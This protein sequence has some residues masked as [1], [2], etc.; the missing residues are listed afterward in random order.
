MERDQR[1]M[2]ERDLDLTK[3]FQIT[4]PG[5]QYLDLMK[6]FRMNENIE[7]HNEEI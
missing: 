1:A 4:D 7:T 2:P 5:R 6:E 3:Y